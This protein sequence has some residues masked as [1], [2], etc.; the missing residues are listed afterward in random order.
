MIEHNFHISSL[1]AARQRNEASPIQEKEL[2]DWLNASER[3]RKFYEEIT[4]LQYQHTLL[5]EFKAA[6]SSSVWNKTLTKIQAEQ[7]IQKKQ[8]IFL[9]GFYRYA[10]AAI[11]FL[12]FGIGAW[13]M[14]DVQ[15]KNSADIAFTQDIAPAKSNAV[16][17]LASG[18]KISLNQLKPGDLVKQSGMKITKTASGQLRF[19]ITNDKSTSTNQDFNKIETSKGTQYQVLL[20]DGTTIWLNASSS[21][22]FP[23][24]F[25]SIDRSV[26]LQGEAYFEVAHEKSRPFK[27]KT[28]QQEVTVL[29]THFNV[30]AYSD[31]N[32][33]NTTL[34]QGSVKVSSSINHQSV[35]I[36]PGQQSIANQSSLAV[37]QVDVDEVIAWKNGYFNFNEENLG[38]IMQRISRWYNIEVDFEDDQLKEQIFSGT[39]SQ[40]KNISQVIKVLE[41]T[42]AAKFSIE[43]NKILISRK[44]KP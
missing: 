29:G 6:N 30:S 8:P 25:S 36:K 40:Y 24:A 37:Q 3:N 32:S 20:P 28:R 12:T 1:I 9:N 2:E 15:K 33:T 26:E 22:K 42:N 16:L 35:I 10:A 41:L 13:Y 23:V 19:T 34:L 4:D 38:H 7:S 5:E 21:I 43:E 39:V 11:L 18:Q 17:T 31:E 44:T 14:L 27:V